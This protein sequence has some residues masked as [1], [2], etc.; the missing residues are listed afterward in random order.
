MDPPPHLPIYPAI[1]GEI[2]ARIL[3][4][5]EKGRASDLG[6]TIKAY[7][8]ASKYYPHPK[9]RGVSEEGHAL[10]GELSEQGGAARTRILFSKLA[11]CHNRSYLAS[12]W[13]LHVLSGDISPVVEPFATQGRKTAKTKQAAHKEYLVAQEAIN[14]LW[15]ELA[16]VM[17][18]VRDS[19]RLHS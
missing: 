16:Q 1:A 5:A 17:Q 8:A 12:R 11:V 19:Y 15:P 6:T 9:V 7:A 14:D 13:M 4:T 18:S 2:A 3:E 10:L